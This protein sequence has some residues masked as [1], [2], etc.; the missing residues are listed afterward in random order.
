VFCNAR[1]QHS[2]HCADPHAPAPPAPLPPCI[3]HL[4]HLH[5]KD[6]FHTSLPAPTPTSLR[7]QGCP[8]KATREAP[9][10]ISARAPTAVTAAAAANARATA[11]SRRPHP[12]A[13]HPLTAAGSLESQTCPSSLVG[14]EHYEAASSVRRGL[15]SKNQRG[16]SAPNQY[17]RAPRL[18]LPLP[19]TPAPPQHPVIPRPSEDP[20]TTTTA[21]GDPPPS[22]L[23]GPVLGTLPDLVF[24]QEV[25]RRL[26]PTDLA[27]LAGAG[28]GCA[29]AV[30]ATA[31]MQWAKRA[32]RTAPGHLARFQLPLL[33]LKE[34]CS[35]AARV[36]NREVLEWLHDTGCPFSAETCM[37]AAQGGHLAGLQW[38]R[39]QGCPWDATTCAAAALAGHLRVLQWARE[40]HCLWGWLTPSLGR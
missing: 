25:L 39:E 3:L 40:H 14:T 37:F 17:P 18:L 30:A 19:P 35:H 7:G 26:G 10:L 11:N 38:A 32:K 28:R 12:A 36:G 21:Q 33:C 5:T 9:T 6:H 29:A 27:S 4:T 16:K 15:P 23:F 1:S 22:P 34:A 13:P 2:V 8:A 20:M 24:Q 31:F